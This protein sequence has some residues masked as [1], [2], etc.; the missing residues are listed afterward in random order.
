ELR[1]R[2][3]AAPKRFARQNAGPALV[4]AGNIDR[5]APAT[6]LTQ[7]IPP[8][9]GSGFDEKPTV[10][11]VLPAITARQRDKLVE[12]TPSRAQMSGQDGTPT[13]RIDNQIRFDVEAGCRRCRADPA[14]R[15]ADDCRRGD[16]GEPQNAG[17]VGG[18]AKAGVKDASIEIVAIAA[19]CEG[20]IL[21]RTVA[22]PRADDPRAPQMRVILNHVLDSER[23]QQRKRFRW[24]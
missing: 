24:E 13:R 2:M 22:Q 6:P 16:P 4:G 23:L 3:L 17:H 14:V 21:D 11:L 1:S 18:G 8:P 7:G 9:I 15:A 19:K 5:N 12:E 20:I 10:T